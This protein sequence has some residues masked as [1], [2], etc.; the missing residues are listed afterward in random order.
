MKVN[1]IYITL[2]IIFTIVISVVNIYLAKPN[3]IANSLSLSN[4]GLAQSENGE[5]SNG[6]PSGG[7]IQDIYTS[8]TMHESTY[9]AT[10]WQK[11][12]N[13]VFL[14]PIHHCSIL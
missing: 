4:I 9:E 5:Q 2:G 8:Y 6:M 7:C 12:N 1:R 10:S 13:Y 14:Y 11:K 3:V